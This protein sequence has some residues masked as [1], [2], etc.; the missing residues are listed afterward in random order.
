MWWGGGDGVEGGAEFAGAEEEDACWGGCGG[1][2]GWFEVVHDGI[3]QRDVITTYIYFVCAVC[4][5]L[6]RWWSEFSKLDGRECS[7]KCQVWS[8]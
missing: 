7:E 8:A 3:E 2:F 5:E 6:R 4:S 1:H